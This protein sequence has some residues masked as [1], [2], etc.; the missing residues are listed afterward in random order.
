MNRQVL[1]FGRP[2]F[3]FCGVSAGFLRFMGDFGMLSLRQ[4]VVAGLT[5][6]VTAG[7]AGA[8]PAPLPT[9]FECEMVV[10]TASYGVLERSQ[11]TTKGDLMRYQK[12][13]G[14]GLKILFIRNHQGTYHLNMHTNDGAKW[15]AS[16]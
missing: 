11:L 15:P 2:F 6:A 14:A 5:L 16:W 9:T 3:L 12:R 8:A 4:H 7:V 10:R 13:T 1:A